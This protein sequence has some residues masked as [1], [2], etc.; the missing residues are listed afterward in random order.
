[1]RSAK[2]WACPLLTDTE[3]GVGFLMNNNA[4]GKVE[5]FCSI[6]KEAVGFVITAV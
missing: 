6:I 5:E 4:A 2:E 3:L 1:M